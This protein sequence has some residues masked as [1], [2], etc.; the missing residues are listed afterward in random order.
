[1]GVSGILRLRNSGREA[2]DLT[3]FLKKFGN[4]T[5]RKPQEV[6]MK[7][8]TNK[9]TPEI[10]NDEG[11]H[12]ESAPT[13][14]ELQD[15]P[16]CGEP[17]PLSAPSGLCPK[18]AMAAVV[19]QDAAANT[20]TVAF[21]RF[22]APAIEEVAEAFPQL[23]VL[24]LIGCGGMG[25]VYK[26]RQLHLD[27]VVALKI[28]PKSLAENPEFTERFIREAQML[29]KLNHP[30]IVGIFDFGESGG[31]F[32]LLMEFVDGVNLRQAMRA[33]RFTP[34]QALEV[35]PEIC[36]ALQFAHDE[37]VLHRDIK[38]ENILLDTRGKIKIADFGIAKL[39]DDTARGLTLTQ[40]AAPGTPQYMA[41]EQIEEP[42]TVDH[43]ADI[44]SLGV[45][46]YEMLTGELPIG[47]F[48]APSEKTSVGA[49][50]D[51]IVF[52]TLE[53]ERDRRQQSAHEVQ[54]DLASVPPMTDA[55]PPSA[56]GAG[57]SP[58]KV[59]SKNRPT[60]ALLL[61]F[62]SVAFPLLLFI[63]SL[64]SANS[65]RMQEAQNV[66]SMRKIKSVTT[67]A[68]AERKREQ[69]KIL[70][71]FTVDHPE[72]KQ[73]ATEIEVLS[74]QENR[75]RSTQDSGT[76]TDRVIFVLLLGVG[77]VAFI[78][79]CA[80]PATL[81]AWRQLRRQ[82]V[83][84]QCQ[85]RVQLLTAAWCWPMILLAFTI[86]CLFLFSLANA[87]RWVLS[88][89][90]LTAI[91]LGIPLIRRTLKWL[92]QSV[93]ATERGAFLERE[94]NTPEMPP[95]KFRSLS[96]LVVLGGVIGLA[97]LL[98]SL[99]FAENSFLATAVLP[100]G[101]FAMVFIAL[102]LLLVNRTYRAG[103]TAQ[104]APGENPWPKRVF[105]LVLVMFLAPG[106]MVAVSL[107][108]PL[109]ASTTPN[110]FEGHYAVAVN[111]VVLNE[112]KPSVLLQTRRKSAGIMKAKVV[113]DGP[114][115][116][117][118][119]VSPSDDMKRIY[120]GENLEWTLEANT[121]DMR[122]ILFV[123]PEG[124]SG[125]EA[126]MQMNRLAGKSSRNAPMYPELQRLPLFE[127]S[128]GS[129]QYRA[130]VEFEFVPAS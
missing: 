45:V 116:Q 32:F 17:I 57:I 84:G 101:I 120:P 87:P 19:D 113:F 52:R 43:R 30:K 27:R 100:V 58:P 3:N 24:N 64:L 39:L 102:T 66:A 82:R 14:K 48:A 15:C 33:G 22:E 114:S 55:P 106:A 37:G 47:R 38:P 18:C 13:P 77:T 97:C 67:D 12:A 62:C 71:M 92:S 5:R 112:S 117:G 44:Y 91:A 81:F 26:A 128:N 63:S 31:Y 70:A 61:T 127:L 20:A 126:Y 41:P 75:L 4:I 68:L 21:P 93:T 25:A 29:A 78:L 10:K 9:E 118:A 86:L 73:V 69:E 8:E 90:V 51:E 123:L 34:D 115:W 6:G 54:T 76:P 125:G 50:V 53:K 72:A 80:I 96:R 119:Q 88:L 35:V 110:H 28:L 94:K 95:F 60:L 1:M 124:R 46:L 129:D 11:D 121:L 107:L 56:R 79:S 65:V 85:G 36:E 111:K 99:L 23:E 108:I 130:W 74:D 89:S 2:V 103:S 105:W 98:S 49:E 42:T 7:D 122:T 59:D 104:L 109:M 16:T 40:G 83:L